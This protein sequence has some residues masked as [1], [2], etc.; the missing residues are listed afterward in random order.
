MELLEASAAHAPAEPFVRAEAPRANPSLARKVPPRVVPLPSERSRSVLAPIRLS[1]FVLVLVGTA[2]YL[3]GHEILFSTFYLV[4]VAIAAW[5]VGSGFASAIAIASV[6]V[7]LIGD[8]AA[9]AAYSHPFV[10]VWNFIITLAFY[11][12]VV[13]LIRRLRA[14]QNDLE[15]RVRL[16]TAALTEEMA[17]RQRLEVQILDIGERERER[18]G[19]DLH[20]SLGQILTG[21]ALAGQV[22]Q[23]KLGAHGLPEA[24]EAGRLVSLVEEAIEFTRGLA[25]GL[26]PFDVEGGG[27]AEALDE[28]VS[29]TNA[30]SAVRCLFQSV[31][32]LSVLDRTTATHL[33]RI[34]QE[35]MTNALKHGH[36]STI[37]VRLDRHDR[38]VRLTVL[39]NGRGIP[40]SPQRKAGLGMRIMAHRAAM[41]GATLSVWRGPKGQTTVECVLPQPS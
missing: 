40:D 23:E 25:R 14:M 17:E 26:D 20:D 36:P 31:G 6:G 8:R 2:D 38:N 11:F 7:W 24:A 18:I 22:L 19:R 16:R 41:I 34:A 13:G 15:D 28:L 27:I 32:E 10:E 30:L 1:I 5:Y 39:D 35:A 9:G 37:L 21:T 29:R 12:V 3:T 4:P 33:Y